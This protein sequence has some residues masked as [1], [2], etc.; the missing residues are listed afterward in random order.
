MTENVVPGPNATVGIGCIGIKSEDFG[1][2]QANFRRSGKSVIK[3]L[4]LNDQK[5]GLSQLQVVDQF[6]NGVSWVDG[7]ENGCLFALAQST[8]RATW[9][10]L[11]PEPMMPR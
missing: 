7:C 8:F 2:C 11:P 6:V 1:L 3:E 10:H 5:F 4:R 9:A